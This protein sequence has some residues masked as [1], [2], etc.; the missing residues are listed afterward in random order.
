MTFDPKDF[1]SSVCAR[2][3]QVWPI[4]SLYLCE[5]NFFYKFLCRDCINE[6]KEE[7]E[8]ET[9]VES[10]YCRECKKPLKGLNVLIEDVSAR[11]LDGVIDRFFYCSRDCYEK[12]NGK[13]DINPWIKNET[14][15][16]GMLG[17]EDD[18]A[19]VQQTETKA[20]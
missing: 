1:K 12:K 18:D 5:W 11:D 14:E 17:N 2:C 13:I 6:I 19:R 3:R 15:K 20:E 7:S 9:E 16:S 8:N 4:N 10:N